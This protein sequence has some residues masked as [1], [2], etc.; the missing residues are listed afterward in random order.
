MIRY[1]VD[2]STKSQIWLSVVD[3]YLCRKAHNL[4][5]L[6]KHHPSIPFHSTFLSPSTM[7][8]I[9]NH[10]VD[11]QDIEDSKPALWCRS[12]KDGTNLTPSEKKAIISKKVSL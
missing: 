11:P 12:I 8:A 2:L 3:P 10:I 1:S 4:S 6:K 7:A 5:K 9:V